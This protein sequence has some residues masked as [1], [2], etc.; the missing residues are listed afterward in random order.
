MRAQISGLNM[1]SK[2]ANDTISLIQTAEGAMNETHS[3]LQRLREL[4]DS[5]PVSLA[6]DLDDVLSTDSLWIDVDRV[7]THEMVHAVM[8]ASGINW[9]DTPKWFKEGA[10]EYVAGANERVR[11]SLNMAAG[12]YSNSYETASASKQTQAMQSVLNAITVSSSSSDFYSASYLATSYLDNLIQN[13]SPGNTIANFMQAI[14][15][16][17]TFDVAINMY[18]GLADQNAFLA[19]FKDANG[20]NFLASQN[21]F[22]PA[23]IN[24][25]GSPLEGQ[26]INGTTYGIGDAGLIPD[27]GSPATTSN[28]FKYDWLPTTGGT[29]VDGTPTPTNL[30]GGGGTG[31]GGTPPVIQKVDTRNLII[32]VGANKDQNI[33]LE[34]LAISKSALEINT[35]D[36]R[37]QINS[38]TA[39]STIDKAIQKVSDGRSKYGAYQNRLEHTI[40]NLQNT[41]EN[42]TLAESRIRDADMAKEMMYFTKNNILTQVAQAMLSQSNQQSQVVLQL[43]S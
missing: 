19:D 22:D 38:E 37:T 13:N 24:K 41:A 28:I 43:L 18:T 17:T 2:N 4:A 5:Y 12:G 32:H 39:I 21:L 27:T 31:G 3:M 36:I 35:V 25:T 9:N 26:T 23:N 7:I 8:S 11:S 34:R 16:G 33:K 42:L 6:I 30:G 14:S 15:N 1:A 40:N 20:M 29:G 10:A